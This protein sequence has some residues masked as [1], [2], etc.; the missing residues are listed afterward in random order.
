MGEIQTQI[1]GLPHTFRMLLGDLVHLRKTWSEDQTQGCG[2]GPGGALVYLSLGPVNWRRDSNSE[3]GFYY[4]QYFSNNKLG[5]ERI[6][7]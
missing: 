3:I 6:N 5:N 4:G 1:Q 2:Q 7:K